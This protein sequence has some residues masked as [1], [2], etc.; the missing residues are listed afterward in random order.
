MRLRFLPCPMWGFPK[1]RDPQYSRQVVG[2]PY[3]KD[4]KKV[5]LISE[6]PMSRGSC[7]GTEPC[8]LIAQEEKK[9]QEE[10]KKRGEA[11][12]RGCR[13]GAV[14]DVVN[15]PCPQDPTVHPS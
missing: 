10:A 13:L 1:I 6:T 2:I 12:R 11:R 3:K 15:P 5:T 7:A 9:R 14:A 4:P 8:I